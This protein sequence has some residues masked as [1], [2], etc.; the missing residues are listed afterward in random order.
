[1]I[2]SIGVHEL[3]YNILNEVRTWRL[4][5]RSQSLNKVLSHSESQLDIDYMERPLFIALKLA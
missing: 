5:L 3:R 1:M 2:E 4:V